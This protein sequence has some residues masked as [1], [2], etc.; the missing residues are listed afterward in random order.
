M[1]EVTGSSPVSSTLEMRRLWCGFSRQPTSARF[2]R[3]LAL[4]HVRGKRLVL[5]LAE[6]IFLL[7]GCLFPICLQVVHRTDSQLFDI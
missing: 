1:A 7:L 5:E 2:H 3:C 6:A 4:E